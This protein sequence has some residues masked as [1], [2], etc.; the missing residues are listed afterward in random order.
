MQ[1]AAGNFCTTHRLSGSMQAMM[2]GA[3]TQLRQQA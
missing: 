1:D 3:P 2:A